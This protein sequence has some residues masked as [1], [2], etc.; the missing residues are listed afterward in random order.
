MTEPKARPAA[1]PAAAPAP[2]LNTVRLRYFASIREALGTG[3]ESYATTATTVAL[4]RAELAAGS[5][6]HALALG[7]GRAVRAAINQEM[8]PDDAPLPTGCEVAFFPPVT[9]G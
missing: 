7:A 8:V 6:A 9:G 1:A 2:G 5:A 3:A 4:L